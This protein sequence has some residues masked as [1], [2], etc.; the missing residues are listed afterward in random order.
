MPNDNLAHSR[1]RRK[2]LAR[3]TLL[4]FVEYGFVTQI[5]YVKTNKH[6]NWAKGIF[7]TFLTQNKTKGRKNKMKIAKNKT[8]AI[9]IAI[10]LM[11]SMAASTMLVPTT[12]AHT[13]AWQIQM[14]A[15]CNVG[16][17]PAGIGQTVTVNFWLNEPPPTA[18][19]PYG[20]RYRF[21]VNV[22]KPDGT[23]DTLGPFNSDD[24][25]GTSTQYVPT[26]VGTYT[27]QAF[28]PGET[29]TGK[30]NN[31]TGTSFYYL[32]QFAND[33]LLP[34]VSPPATLTVQQEPIPWVPVA[35]LPTQYWQTPINAMNVLNWYAIGGP[36]L[37]LYMGYGAGRGGGHYNSSTNFNPYSTAPLTSHIM[38]TR[39]VAPGGA[40]GGDA[41]GT[42]TYGNYYST[43]QYERKYVPIVINGVMYYTQFPGSINNPTSNIAVDL[44]T[45]KTIWTDDS[46]NWGGGDPQH[47][48]LDSNGLVAPFTCGQV[49]DFVSPNQYG[50]LAYLWTAGTPAWLASRVQP[51]STT[52]NMFDA[53]T[54]KYI[55]SVVNGTSLYVL[56]ASGLNVDKGG[57]LIDYYINNTIG[58]QTIYGAPQPGGG[59]TPTK[60]TTAPG[61]QL[62]EVWNS[63]QAI[64]VASGWQGPGSALVP[65]SWRPPQ[66]AVIP[67][68]YGIQSAW[69]TNGTVPATGVANPTLPQGFSL[70]AV[71]SGV[72]IL[73]APSAQGLGSY[74]QTGFSIY[75][76]IDVE[77]GNVLFT[78][79]ITLTPYTAVDLDNYGNVGNG[80]FIN[81]IKETGVVTAYSVR[82]GQQLWQ[83]KLTGANGGPINP[84]DTVGGIKGNIYGNSFIVFGFGGD[85]WSLDM[86]TGKVNWY[87]NT[88]VTTGDA[89]QNTPYGIWPIWVQTGIGGGGGIVFLEEGHE[90]SPPLFLGAQLLALNTTDGSLVWSIHS[91]DVDA[92]PTLAYGIMTTLNAY[93][94]QVYA[95]GR[96][97]S[98]TTVSAPQV[99]ATTS[100]PVTITGTV[101]D[102][103]AGSKQEAVA[104]NFPNGLP[105]VSDDSM[106]GWMEYVYMQQPCPTTVTGVP[107]SIDV[108][109]S[110][111]NY[112]NIG[113][114]T[115]D[116]SGTFAF[117]WTPDIPG[118]FTVIATF[119]GSES[120]YPSNAE[121]HFY[122][123]VPAPTAPPAATAAPSAADLYF[124]P[125]VIAIIVVIIIGFAVLAVL[126]LRKRP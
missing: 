20:D 67:F 43:S 104:A 80:A 9:A 83:T 26:Q 68:S 62:L 100:T 25:G 116:G 59:P 23:N 98:A 33:T 15:F 50:G 114:A 60:V 113:T 13:P 66:A 96:G 31:P 78:Q 69:L 11:L 88:T 110:N 90:Y 95:Y 53:M 64:L 102:V 93:D 109:D 41:G 36:Y 61:Q 22:I 121:A 99:G 63:T 112:R 42:T 76:G 56:G 12:N 24:T 82:T 16:P 105:C 75:E 120:Y 7:Y 4:F 103:A 18:G 119:A 123:A 2:Y 58:T 45:G 87:T 71:N 1:L 8:A 111:G 29:L 37:D 55:L 92:N 47:S 35:P 3:T 126:M 77:T 81:V 52:L 54:G 38:W 46:S 34:A 51:F 48:M 79:N 73:Y 115:S 14:F 122:A 84:Y 124:V 118:D 27:F 107:I 21:T 19:G 30:T 108:L 94:N 72:A 89:G 74:F 40:I 70:K 49:L 85:V 28:F 91:F 32:T 17:N 86:G 106:T 57:N 117:T 10:F 39:P 44:Y 125:S 6:D 101:T 65:W 5:I 97:P